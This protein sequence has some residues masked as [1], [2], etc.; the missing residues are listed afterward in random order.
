MAPKKP[1]PN[2]KPGSSNVPYLNSTEVVPHKIRTILNQYI[3]K[4]EN[5]P[6]NIVLYHNDSFVLLRDQYPKASIH[7]L[8]LPRDPEISVIHP[9]EALQNNVEFRE[10]VK[11]ELDERV[12][13]LVATELR[14]MFGAESQSDKA[15]Q[16]DLERRISGDS[17]AIDA[18]SEARPSDTE[19]EASLQP[20]GRDWIS[21]I[22]TGIHFHPSLSNLHIHIISQ[23]MHS[24][25]L[26]H[27]KHYNSFNTPFFVPVSAFPLSEDDDRLNPNMSHHY[28]K[29]DLVCW[30]CGEN[31]GARFVKLKE[32]L[33]SEW[34]EWKKE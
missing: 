27:K 32:H 31:F 20:T 24:P 14:R 16:E 13:P 26:K 18:A 10:R 3:T 21:T 25:S 2:P 11:K 9:L 7:L 33:Q 30:R 17:K 29:R 12:I 19:Q 22:R 28:L 4:P 8:L 6:S 5:F 15:Y 23:D 34:E 1:K